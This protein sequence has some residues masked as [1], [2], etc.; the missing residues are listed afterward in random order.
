MSEKRKGNTTDSL[1]NS[2]KITEMSKRYKEELDEYRRFAEAR[3][4]RR[5]HTQEKM[6]DYYQRLGEYIVDRER[7][8]KP[9][10]VAG[11]QLALNV[12]PRT[13][14][15]WNNG[16]ADYL[17][18]EYI[19]LNHVSEDDLEYIDDIPWHITDD[20]R[21]MLIPFSCLTQKAYQ[22]IQNQLEEN[23]Y[24][25][26]GNPAGSIFSL[27]AQFKWREEDTPQH[28]VQNLVIADSEQAKKAMAM[29][30]NG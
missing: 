9:L 11:V 21:V 8:H 5:K 6:G 10:T 23:C 18:E 30:T 1:R 7:Q 20:S 26:K 22:M 3:R 14:G 15:E 27:K 12:D 2:N 29:L 16:D 4:N 28:L 24:T 19:A 17:L 13:W 25:N